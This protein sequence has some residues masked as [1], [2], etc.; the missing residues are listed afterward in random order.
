MA[1]PTDLTNAVD[2]TTEIVAAH[3]NNL[4][5]KVGIDESE[6][7]LSL[8]YRISRLEERVLGAW[9]AKAQDTIYQAATDGFVI[10]S[11]QW[12]TSNTCYIKSDDSTPPTTIRGQILVSGDQ[13]YISGATATV[14]IRKDDYWIVAIT[15]GT[16]PYGLLIYWIPLGS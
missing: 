10:V 15:G 5:A 11:A 4:E 2:E 3:L 6:D 1:F 7:P 13:S 8:D 12:R 14:P 9:D 16:P